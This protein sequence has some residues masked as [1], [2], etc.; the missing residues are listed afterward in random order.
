MVSDKE[1]NI[2]FAQKEIRSLHYIAVVRN[3]QD[4]VVRGADMSG[5]SE[6]VRSN[7]MALGTDLKTVAYAD[8]LFKA[9][10]NTDQAA[11]AQAA[12][13]LIGKAADGSNLTLDP[14]LDSYYT[15][16]A[17][18]VK[19]PAAVAGAGSLARAVAKTAE[20]ELSIHEQVNIGV[21]IG[22]LQPILKAL[23]SDIENAVRGN[24]TGTVEKTMTPSIVLV[25]ETSKV[26]VNSFTD[27]DRA[28]DAWK[29]I[30]PLLDVLTTAGAADAAEV[31]YLLNQRLSGFRSAEMTSSGVALALFLTAVIYVL[32]VVQR[33]AIRPLRALTTT[34]SELAARNLAIKID[35]M[36]RSD[37]IGGMARAVQ[38][39]KDS[40]IKADALAAREA[41]SIRASERRFRGL[42]QNTHDM[43]LIC[44]APGTITYQSPA[45]EES[46][47]YL[48]EGLLGKL[49]IGLI[50][51]ED[52]PALWELWEQLR[53][54]RPSGDDGATHTTELRLRDA[55]DNWRHAELVGTNCLHDSAI[56][57]MV[58]TIRDV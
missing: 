19:I 9:L 27:H 38:V 24:P 35:G 39:F 30:Q 51:L 10:A 25:T 23:V 26:A 49:L 16:D 36:A 1:A 46:W 21:Q 50:H 11:A 57:G 18:T 34:M 48:A 33:G 3:V 28:A 53:Q 37:E 54:A 20:H 12:A 6:W 40:M 43:I 4:A 29:I 52:Q 13:D 2:A 31:E 47:N 45:A 42:V 58:V 55:G 5:L 17:L 56:M 22:G 32:L 15:Q 14:D 8:L 44:T 41:A 7:E